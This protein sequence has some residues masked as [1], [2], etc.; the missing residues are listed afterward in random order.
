MEL[1]F[2]GVLPPNNGFTAAAQGHPVNNHHLITPPGPRASA[3]S[4]LRNSASLPRPVSGYSF[5]DRNSE[6]CEM[7]KGPPMSTG[8][9]RGGSRKACNE[10]K[11]QKVCMMMIDYWDLRFWSWCLTCD[12]FDVILCRHQPQRARAAGDCRLTAK[13]S[14]LLNGFQNAG[15]WCNF[16]LNWTGLVRSD[17]T[18]DRRN[19]EME[20]EIVDLRRRLATNGDNP[21]AVEAN[22]SDGMS[23]CSE[24]VFGGPES[25]VSSAQKGRPLSA[26]LDPQPLATPLTIHRDDSILSQDDS[27]FT[28]EDVTLSRSRVTRL[29]EQ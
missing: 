17:L 16:V 29:F 1:Q 14:L 18:V 5:S 10:C 6:P 24:D 25:A 20:K 22:T 9:R 8:K 19:A 28:I 2:P 11:Q 7:E 15:Q 26:P 13:S 12:S 23:Q 3:S 4:D 27:L 21:Q